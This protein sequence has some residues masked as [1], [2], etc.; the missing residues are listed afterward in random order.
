MRIP[1]NYKIETWFAI[2]EVES[3][4]QV[5]ASGSQADAEKI[6]KQITAPTE[7]RLIRTLRAENGAPDVSRV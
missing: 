2:Y 4:A 7:V 3:G 5:L 1:K 6:Q